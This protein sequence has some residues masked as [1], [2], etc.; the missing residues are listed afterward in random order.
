[1][2][3]IDKKITLKNLLR[4]NMSQVTQKRVAWSFL[5]IKKILKLSKK[6]FK[7]R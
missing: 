3:A 7:N 1:M 6:P 4:Y 2:L 5:F